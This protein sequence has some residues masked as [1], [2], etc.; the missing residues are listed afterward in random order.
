MSENREKLDVLA[1]YLLEK[2]PITGE[3]FMQLLQREEKAEAEQE[4][5]DVEA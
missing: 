4:S 1:Q 5:A 3:E 2:E